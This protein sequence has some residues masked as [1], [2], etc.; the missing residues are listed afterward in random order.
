MKIYLVRHA[1]AIDYQTG[2][3][4]TDSLRY[5]TSNG[6]KISREVFKKLKDEFCDLE[7]IFTSPLIRAVQTAEILAVVTKFK[8]DIEVVKE[9]STDASLSDAIKLIKLNSSFDSI[10]LAG[11]EPM[12]G[13][14]S[15]SLSG[16]EKSLFP[17]K[18]SAVCL[19]DYNPEKQ[20][21]KFIWMFNPKTMEF[22]KQ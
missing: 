21:G 19:V 22:Q 9:L 4:N 6:R 3:V 17:F 13:I 20:T 10:A 8:N 12:M 5:L 2:T 1:E 18:K 11:H 14:L 16:R 15:A 7:K